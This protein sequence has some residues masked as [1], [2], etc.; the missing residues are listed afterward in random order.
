MDGTPASYGLNLWINGEQQPTI[1]SRPKAYHW[2]TIDAPGN[3]S[4]IPLLLDSRWRGGGPFY[5]YAYAYQAA[6][7]P[8]DYTASTGNGETTGYAT[9]EMEHFA[10]PRHGKRVNSVFFD[11][12]AHLVKLKDLWGLQWHRQWDVNAWRTKP[13]L[14]PAWMN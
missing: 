9:Y 14:F 5:D 11:G 3:A 10:F 2:G 8:D 1:Q 12:P 13:N 7:V 4:N 6:N